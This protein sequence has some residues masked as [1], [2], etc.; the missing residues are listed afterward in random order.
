[1]AM[2]DHNARHTELKYILVEMNLVL[3]TSKNT[4][5]AKRIPNGTRYQISEA[6]GEKVCLQQTGPQHVDSRTISSL[7]TICTRRLFWKP[8]VRWK[9][10]C[11]AC[12]AVMI[13]VRR[14]TLERR[15]RCLKRHPSIHSLRGQPAPLLYLPQKNLYLTKYVRDFIN[16]LVEVENPFL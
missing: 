12:D 15:R 1:M 7:Q 13:S 3:L 5:L 11:I 14:I 2:H 16:I 6:R 8:S 4:E 10:V 9:K